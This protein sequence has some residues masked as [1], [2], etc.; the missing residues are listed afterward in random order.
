MIKLVFVIGGGMRKVIIEKR[1]IHFITV[2]LGWKPLSINL[3]KLDEER[4]KID[5]CGLNKDDIAKISL[6]KTEEDIANDIK[7]DFQRSGWRLT[8]KVVSKNE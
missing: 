4:E 3:D 6:L 8:T 1:T 2:E 5:K 7:K